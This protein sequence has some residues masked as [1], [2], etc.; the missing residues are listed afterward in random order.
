MTKAHTGPEIAE[1]LH[2]AAEAAAWAP[3]VHNTQPWAFAV[4]GDEISLRADTDRRLRVGDESGREMLI[5]CGASLLNTRIA[6]RAAGYEP[7]VRVLPDPDRP[8]L[9]ATVRP[10]PRIAMDEHTALLHA[11]IERRR[12]HRAGFSGLPVADELLEDL[13]AQAETEGAVLT[14]VRSPAGVRVLAALTAAA[15]EIQ[16]QDRRF[17]LEVLRWARPPGST[18]A[19]GVPA[20]AYPRETAPTEPGFAQR[21]YADGHGWGREADQSL[22][23]STGAVAVL[24]TSDDTRQAWLSAGQA[25][26]RVLLHASAYG[27]SAAFHTQTLEL[28]LLREVIRQE[29]CSGEHPQMIMRLGIALDEAPGVRRALSD[30]LEED[31]PPESAR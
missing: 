4:S 1:A 25:L 30:T 13:A 26:Q 18:R 8:L 19:D 31:P 22:A 17:S 3:S 2:A 7:L 5:G 28:P 14:V 23:A 29:L 12:T 11:E 21:D 15:Q 24:T 9:L 27:A 20:D 6:L 10:G 16:S